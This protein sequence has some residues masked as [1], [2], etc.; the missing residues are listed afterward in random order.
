MYGYYRY[1]RVLHINCQKCPILLLFLWLHCKNK[2]SAAHS[3][4]KQELF[5]IL[6]VIAYLS[7]KCL[8]VV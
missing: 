5:C 2:K 4:K 7:L 1:K 3:E 6:T 8:G